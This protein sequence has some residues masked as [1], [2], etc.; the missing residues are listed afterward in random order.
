MVTLMGGRGGGAG[1]GWQPFDVRVPL[2][3]ALLGETAGAALLVR[4]TGGGSDGFICD[5]CPAVGCGCTVA[6]L[7]P[8]DDAGGGGSAVRM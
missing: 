1:A 7:P 5:G 2:Q 4:A 6:T 3:G 8:W